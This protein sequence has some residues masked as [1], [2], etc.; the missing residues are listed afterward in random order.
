MA[1][2]PTT[3]QALLDPQLDLWGSTFA[4]IKSM[5]LKSAVDLRIADAIERHGGAATLH[6]IAANAG[7]HPAKV[8]CLRRLMRVLTATGVFSTA[9]QAVQRPSSAAAGELAV[10][11]LTPTSRLLVGSGSLVRIT[12]MT[13][14]PALVSSFF[15]PVTCLR[16]SRRQTQC[17]SS[18]S[19]M[20]GMT[21]IV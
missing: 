16:A 17:S 14:H 8:P 20:T 10:Y 19:C 18:G 12:A 4:Y 5:A 15:E 6:Q 1:L 2:A 11:A 13:L 7:V 21:R 9:V 3:G